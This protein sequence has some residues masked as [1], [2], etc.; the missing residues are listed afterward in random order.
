M[1]TFKKLVLSGAAGALLF[2]GPLLALAEEA[3]ATVTASVRTEAVKTD[4]EV[5]A[6][7]EVR[8]KA[9]S[10]TATVRANVEVK[11]KE[12]ANQEIDRRVKLLGN[13]SARMKGTLQV[14]GQTR[15]SI[16]ATLQAQID[17]LTALKAKIDAETSTT[18][19]REHVKSITASYRTFALVAPKAAI[20][21]YADR[22][23]VLAGQMTELGV[24][25]QARIDAATSTDKTAALSAMADFNAKVAD[26]KV[27]IKAALDLVAPLQPDNGDAAVAASNKTKLQ[28]ARAKLEVARKDLETARKNVSAV[29]NA[30]PKVRLNAE[31]SVKTR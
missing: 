18:S 29:R 31:A 23:N 2:G 19:L 27:Q 20:T 6:K 13:L 4:A 12:R 1:N 5:K 22:L 11:A 9:A 30:L 3:G 7:A 10:T 15:A 26:A 14:S 16:S 25:L 17:A 8:A 28:E 24:K 21:A